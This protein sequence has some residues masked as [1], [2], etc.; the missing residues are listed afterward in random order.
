MGVKVPKFKILKL[1]KA[2]Y[3]TKQTSRCWWLHLKGILLDIG[4]V[5]NGEDAST[6]TLNRDGQK[7]ILWVHV[8]NGTLT[9]SSKLLMSWISQQLEQRLKIKWDDEVKG[10]IGISIEATKEGFEFYQLDLIQKLIDL[11]LNSIFAKS[12][13]LTNCNLSSDFSLGNMEKLYLKQK[14]VFLSTLLNLLALTYLM[15]LII[16]QDFLYTLPN[17]T[18]KHSIT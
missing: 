12:P 9:A 18:G 3:G 6:Y 15:R 17:R 5:S 4:F 11:D 7:A 14:E 13:L 16:W 1:R 10:I 2:L 8:D